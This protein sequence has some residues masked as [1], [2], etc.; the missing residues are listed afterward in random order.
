MPNGL[1]VKRLHDLQLDITC[2][3]WFN[4]AILIGTAQSHVAVYDSDLHFLKQYPSLNIGA[5]IGISVNETHQYDEEKILTKTW[6][7]RLDHSRRSFELDE[8]ICQSNE[9]GG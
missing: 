6:T 3:E 5:L 7:N 4:D 8:V 1:A 9:V 2:I